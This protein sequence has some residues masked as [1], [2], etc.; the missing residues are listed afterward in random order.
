MSTLQGSCRPIHLFF[1]SGTSRQ[2]DVWVTHYLCSN[3]QLS[4]RQFAWQIP[5]HS[6]RSWNIIIRQPYCTGG[7]VYVQQQLQ[8]KQNHQHKGTLATAN[9]NMME[10]LHSDPEK[11]RKFKCRL[12]RCMPVTAAAIPRA[13]CTQR[14]GCHLLPVTVNAGEQLPTV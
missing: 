2:I 4:R 1:F 3:F 14:C 5:S 7:D 13:F 9:D 10:T 11:W 6:L 8:L 12:T